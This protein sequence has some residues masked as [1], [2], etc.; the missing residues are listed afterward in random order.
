MGDR[1]A[2][3]RI[4]G[5]LHDAVLDD[6]HWPSTSALIDEACGLT[7][8]GLVVG[9]GPK[10]DIRV[11]FVGL[12]YRGQRREDLEREYLE[13]YHSIDERV[14]RVRRQPYGRLV[15]ITD[16]YTAEELRTS[17]AYN[18]A[19]VPM[20]NGNSLTVRLEGLEGSHIIWSLG[21]PAS[22]GGWGSSQVN[23]LQ[24]LVP[25]VRHFVRVRQ[26]LV[27]AKAA[28]T[29]V[30]ALLDNPRIGVVHLDRRSRVLAA[31]DTARGILLS[32]DGLSDRSGCLRAEAPDDQPRFQRLV[33]A[34]LPATGAA[35]VGGSTLL[36]RS[37][38][39]PPFVVHVKPVPVPQP[40]YGARHVA[41]LVLIHELGRQRR[42]DPGLVATTLG[43][44]TAESQ[45]A[46]WL[47]E[48][49]SVAEMAEAAGHTKGAVYWHLKQIYQK[50][51]VSRQADLVR[52]VLSI[53]DL[54]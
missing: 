41:A 50:L 12:Y 20:L 17:R 43:L 42:V 23:M 31:N 32:G 40:D 25:Q 35:A 33:A 30:S 53:A 1:D 11:A 6:A 44:T 47:A 38:A 45:V 13:D 7:N 9:E 51:P 48:G 39:S 2:F 8:N 22:S 4:L 5:S 49:K 54:G 3:E 21:D 28:S 27:R 24:R 37:S 26:A 18:E 19:A 52:L 14:P 29:T 46:A 36:H 34:A 16:S 10:D 15:H